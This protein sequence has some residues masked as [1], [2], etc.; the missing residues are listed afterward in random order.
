[1][2]RIDELR[3]MAKVARMYYSD[4][5]R[6][7]AICERLNIHQ[8]TVS[9]LL[10]RAQREGMVRITLSF[11]SSTHT[12][13]EEELQSRFGLQEAIVVECLEDDDQLA[14]DLGA[15]AACYMETTLKPNDIIGISC[16]SAALLA[17]VD[18]MRPMQRW[19]TTRVVQILGGVG[20]PDAEVHAT[21][22][23]RRL[24]NLLGGTATML[25]APGIVGTPKARQVLMRDRFV[26]EVFD[27]FPS[28]TLA[29]VGIGAV[30]PSRALASSG[31]IFSPQ[32]LKLLEN[33]GAVGDICLRFFNQAG[34][35][36]ASEL[37]GRV[38]SI[39]LDQLRRARRVVGV[40]GGT[41]KTD[42]I[43]GALAG[44]LIN[45]LITDLA[46]A[47]RLLAEPAVRPAAA[48][49][50]RNKTPARRK[51]EDSTAA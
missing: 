14:H 18:A 34:D 32:E 39:Q 47:E 7:T 23:T 16:W 48:R 30:K 11:P 17:M 10:Q 35:P 19:K 1:M 12:D 29:L 50:G 33:N 36:V 2:A 31:N 38:I 3:L 20:S 46:T 37:N 28:I 4:G 27:L 6:Q 21:Q 40:A 22:L 25:P 51:K 43:R 9:R 13:V 49:E 5:L 26:R 24:A 45:V 8:S 15:A 41:R 42:A 44:Q